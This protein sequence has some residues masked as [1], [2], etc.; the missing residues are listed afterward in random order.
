M[1]HPLRLTEARAPRPSHPSCSPPP[2]P[3]ATDD[4]PRPQPGSDWPATPRAGPAAHACTGWGRW[5]APPL[6]AAA[7]CIEPDQGT[8]QKLL[9]TSILG[10]AN[11]QRAPRAGA[12]AREGE[13]G[14]AGGRA[15]P[16]GEGALGGAPAGMCGRC[17]CPCVRACVRAARAYESAWGNR[18]SVAR[19]GRC[20]NN[21]WLGD[22]WGEPPGLW[23]RPRA[24]GTCLGIGRLTVSPHAGS[25]GVG[26]RYCGFNASGRV[27]HP[28]GWRGASRCRGPRYGPEA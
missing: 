3:A 13:R 26:G 22:G 5:P 16:R 23:P 9:V 17:L 25:N 15:G 18:D 4:A 7:R 6:L 1:C 10:A 2:K 24:V 14:A 19:G 8:P 28:P 11:E 12:R 20:S 21:G 27:G